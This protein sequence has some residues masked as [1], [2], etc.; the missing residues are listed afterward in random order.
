MFLNSTKY[1]KEIS[2]LQENIAEKDE[3]IVKL[4]EEMADYRQTI[5]AFPGV[6]Q[7]YE[8]KVSILNT[9]FN[10]QMET[11]KND[12]ETRITS[13]NDENKR[14]KESVATQVNSELATLGIPHTEAPSEEKISGESNPIEYLT[15]LN[16][17][18][19]NE[20]TEYWIKNKSKI[21]QAQYSLTK[22]NK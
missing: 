15:Q 9:D 5:S 11:L 12:Y 19:G 14:I 17:L 6:K 13:L 10:K 8:S 22:L 20:R 16:N 18:K 4:K 3:A 2:A 21:E 1:L 7:E